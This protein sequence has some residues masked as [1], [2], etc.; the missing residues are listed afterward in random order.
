MHSTMFTGLGWNTH[1]SEEQVQGAFL[2]H[3]SGKSELCVCM[4]VWLCMKQVNTLSIHLC[5]DNMCYN[6]TSEDDIMS[7]HV[8]QWCVVMVTFCRKAL[9]GGRTVPTALATTP[10]SSLQQQRQHHSNRRKIQIQLSLLPRL[11]WLSLWPSRLTIFSHNG[12]MLRWTF[13]Y[14]TERTNN[15][16]SLI[17]FHKPLVLAAIHWLWADMRSAE[18]W[19]T[20][21]TLT[22]INS[23][24]IHAV[25]TV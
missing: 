10:P 20:K 11:P 13:F 19:N 3:W 6:V 21:S 16:I 14:S 18:L 5:D 25:H 4:C 2:L 1:I 7:C 9:V 24:L 23:T 8:T 17:D 12:M 22:L 15:C